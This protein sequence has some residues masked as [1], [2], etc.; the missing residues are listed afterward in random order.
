MHV[1]GACLIEDVVASISSGLSKD[2]SDGKAETGLLS[3]L[4]GITWSGSLKDFEETARSDLYDN[5]VDIAEARSSTDFV[6]ATTSG[7]LK[8]SLDAKDGICE[9]INPDGNVCTSS[10]IGSDKTARLGVCGDSTETG[11]ADAYPR[12]PAETTGTGFLIDLVG[13]HNLL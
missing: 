10:S 3:N 9:F 11:R 4:V 5:L 8:D 7:L 2:L 6:E 1:D 13:G 12:E